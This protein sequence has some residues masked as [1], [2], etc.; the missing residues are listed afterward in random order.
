M[1][2]YPYHTTSYWRGPASKIGD[3]KEDTTLQKNGINNVELV[4]T[5]LS[6]MED[7][8]YPYY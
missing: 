2:C 8:K 1:N 6:D 7:V 3:N 4:Q 5:D